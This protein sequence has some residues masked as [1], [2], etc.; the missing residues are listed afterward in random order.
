MSSKQYECF[1]GVSAHIAALKRFVRLQAAQSGPVLL[2]GERGLRQ[3]QISHALHLRGARRGRPFATV[4][5]GELSSE[6]LRHLLFGPLE[7]DSPGTIYLGLLIGTATLLIAMSL[8][9]GVRLTAG[10]RQT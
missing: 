6:E 7:A 3:E 5:D 2:I 4:S 8:Y 10:V 1:I 9:L